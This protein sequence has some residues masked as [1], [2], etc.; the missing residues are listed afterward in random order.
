MTLRLTKQ[1]LEIL[2]LIQHSKGH[3]TADEIHSALRSQ[4]K[5]VGIATIYRSLNYLFENDLI[6]RVKHPELGF[7]YDK[8]LHQHYHFRCT[9]CNNIQDV[10]VEIATDMDRLIEEQLGVK[11][12]EHEISFDGICKECLEKLK[13]ES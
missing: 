4:D 7:I 10:E 8:N 13:N 3:M 6:N 1:R 11:V 2:E 12:S 9:V 5:T